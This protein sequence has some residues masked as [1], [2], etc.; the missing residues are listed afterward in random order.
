MISRIVL[1]ISAV[2]AYGQ[3][4]RQGALFEKIRSPSGRALFA[5]QAGERATDK[6]E[7]MF[8][9]K[10]SVSALPGPWRLGK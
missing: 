10:H 7:P 4:S 2:S 5:A 8:C 1:T 9:T 6:G 3:K